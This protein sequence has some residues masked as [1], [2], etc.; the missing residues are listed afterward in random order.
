MDS[1]GTTALEFAMLAPILF[2]IVAGVIEI[3]A[4]A[5]VAAALDFG[6]RRASRM[7][8]T[9]S[10]DGTGTMAS[11]QMRTEALKSTVL[12]SSG[13]ILTDDRLQLSQSSYGTAADVSAGKNVTAG[14]G[15]AGQLVR[16]ELIY[17]QPLLSYSEFGVSWFPLTQ[18]THKSTVLVKN[19]PFPVK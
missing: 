12:S 10:I 13:G 14:P 1:R 6:A 5:T 16:Y 11:D 15:K 3:S 19:E 8:V 2:L 4:Q 7:G 17:I 18:F 9:G